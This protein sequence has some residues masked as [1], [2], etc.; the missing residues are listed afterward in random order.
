MGMVALLT[1]QLRGLGIIVSEASYGSIA[2]QVAIWIGT[3]VMV[4][5]ILFSGIHGSASIAIVKDV[6]ILALAVFL[7]IYLPWHYYGGVTPMFT[8]IHAANPSFFEFPKE[9]LNLTWY[10]STI[11]LTALGYYLYPFNLTSVYAA[12]SASAVRR[13]TILMPLYQVV[14]AFLFLVGFAAI[15]QVPGLKG[16]E[17]DL[18]LFG[19]VKHTFDPWFVGVIGG[20]GVLTA[21]VPGSMILLTASTVIGKNVY[22]EGF[23]HNATDK[24]VSRV[25]RGVLPVFALVAV[26]FVLRGGSTIVAVAI[27]ASSLL[28]QLLPSLLFSLMKK[29]FGNKH[30]AFAGILAGGAVLAFMMTTGSNLGTLFPAAPVVFKSL[31]TGLVA[32]AINALV[33]VAVALFTPRI[34]P[35]G[36]S[37]QPA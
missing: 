27:F 4:S 11:L 14:I 32:L 28:T 25:A 8:A 24:Q 30:A 5:Y 33:F 29:P 12:K 9:G 22:K 6:L 21:L 31:N 19:L 18:A 36:I 15:L 23:V 17:V 1:I 10:N 20:T 7:G 16:A 13:N 35:R 3:V 34:V 2:P 37:A 26:Y